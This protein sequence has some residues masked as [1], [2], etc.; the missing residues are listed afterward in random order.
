VSGPTAVFGFPN[1]WETTYKKY[2][3]IFQAIDK[4]QL[5][6]NELIA[7]TKDSVVEIVQLMRSLTSVNN[8]SMSDVLIL[9]G[10]GRGT[11][12]IKVARSMYEVS[13][14]AEYLEKNPQ[15]AD[16]YLDFAHVIGWR[17]LL[18]TEKSSP[19][20]VTPD[21][22]SEAEAQYNHIKG[23]FEKNGRVRNSWSEKSVKR[24][25]DDIGKADLYELVYGL[26]SMLHH[27]N[28]GGLIGHEMNWDAEALRTGHGALLQTV[29]TLYNVHHTT[30]TGFREKITSLIKDFGQVWKAHTA[31]RD[32][33]EQ[34]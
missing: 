25:A 29:T 9:V 17:Q 12:A 28:I 34:P 13:V 24:M 14:T 21:L 30:G 6:A 19:A 23:K 32:K 1:L 22:K 8:I 3:D 18:Q 5:L 15:E 20:K 7:A 11:G 33:Q 10:N 26:S 27:V 4:V 2:A 16:L 31:A